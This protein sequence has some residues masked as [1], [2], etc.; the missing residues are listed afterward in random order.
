MH[1]HPVSNFRE[2]QKHTLL[3]RII[4]ALD[5]LTAGIDFLLLAQHNLSHIFLIS[6][7]VHYRSY[8][9]NG[10]LWAVADVFVIEDQRESS[11]NWRSLR[12]Y[13]PSRLNCWTHSLM[14]VFIVTVSDI[15][16][17]IIDVWIRGH[18]TNVHDS[19]REC[20]NEIESRLRLQW[21]WWNISRERSAAAT[22][23]Y[24]SIDAIVSV[25]KEIIRCKT[26]EKECQTTSI[27]YHVVLYSSEA[28]CSL[29]VQESQSNTKRESCSMSHCWIIVTTRHADAV[30]QS[31]SIDTFKS[32]VMARYGDR[33]F[34]YKFI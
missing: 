31:I 2:Q 1:L 19:K 13:P 27:L 32:A 26:M 33:Q 18:Q 21:R 4:V 34:S 9:P 28:H 24:R 22:S 3:F 25:P 29:R 20:R 8:C 11:E 5:R 10:F 30:Q 7:A 15:A 17:V 14:D 6:A 16:V 12:N 23:M